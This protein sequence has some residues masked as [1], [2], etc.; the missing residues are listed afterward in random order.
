MV[1]KLSEL[2]RSNCNNTKAASVTL[3]TAITRKNKNTI[4]FVALKFRNSYNKFVI[5]MKNIVRIISFCELNDRAT[6]PFIFSP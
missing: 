2:T 6:T 3:D 1:S 4:D 5:K